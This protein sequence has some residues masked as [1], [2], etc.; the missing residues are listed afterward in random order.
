MAGALDD[1]ASGVRSAPQVTCTM[2]QAVLRL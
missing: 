2:G 1:V